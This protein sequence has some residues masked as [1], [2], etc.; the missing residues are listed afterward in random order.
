[1]ASIFYKWLLLA[2]A[3]F[4]K[5]PSE[6]HPVYVSVVEI[7]HNKAE[8][9]LEMSCRIFTD[10]FEKTLR[11]KTQQKVD[12]INP[13]DKK[14]MEQLVNQYIQQHLK[15]KVNGKPVSL[16]FLGFEQVEESIQSYYQV[17]GINTVKNIMLEDDILYEY[18]SEQM[19]IIHI[20]V[21]GN[22]KSTRLTN[23]DN[24]AT[25]EF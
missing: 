14:A 6:L 13:A 15:I 10:D 19:S 23:P 24:K 17:N 4:C 8:Q 20:T 22:R 1:M 5:S 21:N 25:I 11:G 12:L 16:N 3:F 18:K 9:T 2:A 7:E